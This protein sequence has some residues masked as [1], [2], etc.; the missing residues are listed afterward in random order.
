MTEF[1]RVPL[2]TGV[3]LNV[4]LAGPR[5]A[6]ALILLHGF[7]ESHRAWR[8]L[9]PRLDDGFFLVMPDQRGYAGSDRPV[10]VK[11]YG[12]S[13]LVDDVF[14]L[15][16]A[17]GIERFALAGHDFG[18]AVA[19]AAAMRGDPRLERL[20]ILNAP[21]PLIFQKSLF[22]SADQRAASRYIRLLRSRFAEK[23]IGAMGLGAFFDKTI[24]DNA[25][26]ARILEAE[27]RQYI[28]E[29]SQPGAL[30]AMLNWYRAAKL[31]LPPV[32]LPAPAWLLP[33]APEVAVPTLIIWGMRDPALLPL[34]LDGLEDLVD[35][36]SIVR[37]PGAGHFTPWEAPDDVAQALRAFLSRGAAAR[38]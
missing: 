10:G 31:V 30:T 18:G 37:L 5:D 22:E 16:H 32:R 2:R 33:R 38:A 3:T 13:A 27:R 36:L 25:G 1:Q 17:L 15:A 19:W 29:W 12:T 11:N 4:A 14:A 8:E 34:Q 21:H 24:G 20:A 28:A 7:P 9:A 6:P 26:E 23:A 35:D